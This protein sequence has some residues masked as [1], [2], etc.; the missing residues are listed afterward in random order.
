MKTKFLYL[1]FLVF[2]P[3][4][5]FSQS[6]VINAVDASKYPTIRAEITIKDAAG[7]YVRLFSNDEI[8]VKDGGKD[9]TTKS[10]Y[11]EPNLSR[12]SAI[13]T[14][15]RSASMRL[16]KDG[17]ESPGPSLM[18]IAK[19]AAK[20]WVRA[21][22]TTRAEAT[23]TAFSNDAVWLLNQKFVNSKVVLIDSINGSRQLEPVGG[24]NYNSGF[25][26]DRWGNPGALEVAKFAKYKPIIIFLTDGEHDPNNGPVKTAEILQLA[27]QLNA[28]IFCLTLGLPMPDVL[29]SISKNTGGAY[30]ENLTTE[31][32]VRMIYLDILEKSANL[33]TPAPCDLVW[34]TDCDGGNLTVTYRKL[35]L[36]RDTT[37]VIP[38]DIKPYLEIE[39]RTVVF[40]NPKPGNN[41]TLI[42]ITAK[43]NFVDFTPPGYN[44]SKP[45]FSIIDWGGP[46]PP[47]TL[48]K[49]EFRKIKI[50]YIA[51]PNDSSYYPASLTFVG[52]ACDGL[53]MMPSAEW[54]FVRDIDMG[55]TLVGQA[56]RKTVSGVFCNRTG[57]PFKVKNFKI[58]GGNKNDFKIINAPSNFEI[59]PD[60]CITLTFEFL[61][62]SPGEK[63]SEFIVEEESGKIYKSKIKGLA[64][65]KAELS[66]V[67]II[68]FPS[69][70]CN[71]FF[72]DTTIELSNDG[73]LDLNISSFSITGP[74]AADFKFIPS[75]PG[76]M[77]IPRADKKTI[78]IRFEPATSGL[79]TATLTILSDAGN[80]PTFN[81]NLTG[82]RDSIGFS[83]S[84]SSLNFGLLCPNEKKEL[85]LSLTN[86]GNI[87]SDFVATALAAPYELIETNWT[88]GPSASKEITISF[89]SATEGDFNRQLIITDECNNQKII[90]LTAKVQEA[91]IQSDKL[92]LS[93]TVGSSIDGIIK[94]TNTS[95]HN[96]TVTSAVPQDG[97]FTIIA[98]PLNWN[99]PAG[100][101][102]D[103]TVRYSP[104]IDNI[105]NSAI[106]ITGTPC[107]LSYS[108]AITG[109]PSL[110][111][112]DIVVE[113]HEGYVG[114]IVT[115]PVF[116]RNI[117]KVAE[118]GTK[119]IGTRISYDQTM[120]K[121]LGTEPANISSNIGVG[122]ID[123]TNVPLS[124]MVGDKL[125]S[126]RFEALNSTN[127]QTPLQI[128]NS[129]SVESRVIFNERSG[130]FKLKAASATIKIPII[131]AEAGEEFVMPIYLENIKN[132]TQFNESINTTLEFNATLIEPI[133][134]TPKG[135][136]N[137]D[138]R[139]INLT[140]LPITPD[141][142]SRIANLQFRA[143][144][145]NQE[146]SDIIIRN[147]EVK[148]GKVIFEEIAGKFILS[149]VCKSGSVRLFDPFGSAVGIISF[150]PNP[151]NGITEIEFAT[152]EEGMTEIQ[153]VSYTGSVIMKLV[154]EN[155]KI[156]TYKSIFNAYDLPNGLYFVVM[157]TP[158]DYFVKKLS[159][160][161]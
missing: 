87:Q 120:L 148:T 13:L 67:N 115:V 75:N 26:R 69:I 17:K 151:T 43:N 33:G 31:D 84:Q 161:K 23:I 25:L 95:Q 45:G 36:S 83:L 112:A 3:S 102:I 65:G 40:N 122:Y 42:T 94:I 153:V 1:I 136:V 49:D 117:F 77:V 105:T 10:I 22:D 63:T 142:N 80:N 89:V 141:N 150:N 50:R 149:K 116:L 144:L 27:N 4:L 85:K 57:K 8:T 59:P 32:E 98:P 74:N 71:T 70:R 147:T 72:K 12:F 64:S 34:D 55:T 28:T 48:K 61:A 24:T 6:L 68:N 109:N 110:A 53:T 35:N 114:E 159:V 82:N 21:L 88:L 76:A 78:S 158:T 58:D 37:Y 51:P 97:Q 123:F 9:R 7:K 100:G 29:K 140:N 107:N 46:M 92:T 73:A 154:N 108:A 96:I 129:R 104:N 157:K 56:A 145:G 135:T 39:P 60:T 19:S 15:D 128:S 152:T 156:G 125:F 106:L 124:A 127:D 52:S 79:K 126:I 146:T 133:G 38:L 101:S 90:N 16:N 103:I 18:D 2:L 143:M 121:F 11:C 113:N 93:A 91:K 54:V 66:A 137:S 119:N 139:I 155:L 47:F 14:F 160:I 86:T 20:A 30:Y 111:S 81:I 62:D 130:N 118:S 132:I 5:L 138:K 134:N 131:S 41:D 99:I 44:T